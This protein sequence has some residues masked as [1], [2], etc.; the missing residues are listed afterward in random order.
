MNR[1]NPLYVGIFL[2]VLLAV[3]VIKLNGAKSELS[4]AKQVYASTA[5]LATDLSELK[6][7]YADKNKVKASL[8]RT[9]KNSI[10]ATLAIEQNV[11]N[12]GMT[13]SCESMDIKSLNYL[14]GK[15]LNGA[16]NIT[17]LSVKKLSEEKSS[18]DVGIKW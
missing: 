6:N 4:E 3:L 11:N 2:L 10:L 14:V 1:I 17:S 5:K 9:L 8:Q 13:I 16:Y 18:L 15:L 7:V 12:S